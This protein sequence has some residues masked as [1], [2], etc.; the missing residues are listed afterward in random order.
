M[1]EESKKHPNNTEEIQEDLT[2]T[3]LGQI[4]TLDS[5]LS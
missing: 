3:L 1:R 2:N 5:I 4:L